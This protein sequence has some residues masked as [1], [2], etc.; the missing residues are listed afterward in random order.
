MPAVFPEREGSLPHSQ[1]SSATTADVLSCSAAIGCGGRQP[2]GAG[3]W[4]GFAPGFHPPDCRVAGLTEGAELTH[5]GGT[6]QTPPLS[7]RDTGL[8][9]SRT[10]RPDGRHHWSPAPATRQR[11]YHRR[12]R[13]FHRTAAVLRPRPARAAPGSH[14]GPDGCDPIRTNA[15]QGLPIEAAPGKPVAALFRSCHERGPEAS[16]RHWGGYRW[17][18]IGSRLE[19]RHAWQEPDD[20]DWTEEADPESSRDSPQSRTRP[21]GSRP[22]ARR[23]CTVPSLQDQSLAPYRSPHSAGQRRRCPSHDATGSCR[24]PRS[25]RAGRWRSPGTR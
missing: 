15:R 13:P 23:A 4:E 14:N 25:H 7:A 8:R 16:G 18:R 1:R 11:P 2:K 5:P 10:A 20:Q 3:E 6:A 12:A 9:R 24:E 22:Q 19:V 21:G 17:G